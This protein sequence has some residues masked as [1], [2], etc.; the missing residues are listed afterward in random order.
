MARQRPK[1]PNSGRPVTAHPRKR[2][3]LA[4]S[5]QYLNVTKEEL[6]QV[7]P[8]VTKLYPRATVAE[9]A[10]RSKLPAIISRR[11]LRL[12]L[13]EVGSLYRAQKK[14]LEGITNIRDSRR[15][16]SAIERAAAEL[17]TSLDS[18]SDDEKSSIWRPLE[19]LPFVPSEGHFQTREGITIRVRRCSDGSLQIDHLR[20]AH[21]LESIQVIAR[22]ASR[23]LSELPNDVG[24]R[25]PDL[26]FHNWVS[27]AIGFWERNTHRSASYDVH[28]GEP[29][30]DALAF[31]MHAFQ[32]I[33]PNIK[34]GSIIAA[35]RHDFGMSPHHRIG[36][37][38]GAGQAAQLHKPRGVK[39]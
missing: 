32:K 18:L 35:M 30:T 29:I 11:Q 39:R 14:S 38:P 23:V 2:N 20:P 28:E 37:K 10:A 13:I 17:Q 3:V 16:F 25:P 34:V 21:I 4:E 27:N 8:W 36:A 1:R 12:F 7:S 9:I 15:K 33:D 24:G 19:H 26:A 31:C 22:L 5:L 6:D